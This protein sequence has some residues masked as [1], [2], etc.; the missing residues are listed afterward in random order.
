MKPSG[1]GECFGTSI[2]QFLH[3]SLMVMRFCKGSLLDMYM[4]R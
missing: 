4:G 3:D 1:D 2:E